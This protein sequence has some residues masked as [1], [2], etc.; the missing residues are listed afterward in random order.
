MS[1]A[2]EDLIQSWVARAKQGDDKAYSN[3]LNQFRQLIESNVNSTILPG[4]DTEDL[5]QEFEITLVEAVHDFDPTRGVKFITH[6]YNLLFYNKNGM[7]KSFERDKRKVVTQIS[8]SLDAAVMMESEGWVTPEY[9]DS[10]AGEGYEL[11]ESEGLF[12]FLNTTEREVADLLITGHTNEQIADE[13]GLSDGDIRRI[14][15]RIKTKIKHSQ[16]AE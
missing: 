8:A 9:E 12:E 2:N 1:E 11:V 6:L 4:Y 14:K 10:N 7:I 5:R 3:L 15:K 13:L 16:A